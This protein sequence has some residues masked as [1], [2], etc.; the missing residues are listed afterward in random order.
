[1]HMNRNFLIFIIFILFSCD[2]AD[3]QKI[4]GEEKLTPQE[5]ALGLKEALNF[6]VDDA[7]KYLSKEDG[8]YKSVY[9][10]LLPEEARKITEK[11]KI[12][13]GFGNVE[14]IIVT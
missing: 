7:V 11:L 4:I 10:I 2:P 1:M 8:Y 12:I 9:K 13:P 6:G 3:L 14:E 5:A